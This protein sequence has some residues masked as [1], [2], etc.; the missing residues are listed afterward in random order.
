MF[1]RIA[2]LVV[3]PRTEDPDD[4]VLKDWDRLRAQA[5]TPQERAE[6]DAVFARQ[7]A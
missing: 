4:A 5:Q 2:E 1:D 3:G 6:I 7:V